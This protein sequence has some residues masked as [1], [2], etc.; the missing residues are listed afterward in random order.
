MRNPADWI[1]S[2]TTVKA[3]FLPLV[4]DGQR[5]PEIEYRERCEHA[6]G[7]DERAAKPR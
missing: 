7:N 4:A 3:E 2:G 5:M 6:D 1:S